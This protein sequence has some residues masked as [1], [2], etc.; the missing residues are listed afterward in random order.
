ML[1]RSVLLLI[2]S[3]FI[4]I[5]PCQAAD[6]VLRARFTIEAL[7]T[8]EFYKLLEQQQQVLDEH[9]LNL[10]I[11]PVHGSMHKSTTYLRVDMPYG[12]QHNST[13]IINYADGTISILD[14][15][16]KTTYRTDLSGYEE[17]FADGGL[18]LI[19]PER[20]LL[21]WRYML[22]QLEASP[23][24]QRAEVGSKVL[25]GQACQGRRF[26]ADITH[27]TS[28]DGL[29]LVPELPTLRNL[30]GQWVATVW[31]SDAHGL[32][33]KMVMEFCGIVLSLQLTHFENTS[34]AAV[35]FSSPPGY[36]IE[37]VDTIPGA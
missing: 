17:Q 30:K 20:L 14:H 8:P 5:Q 33:V 25:Y 23:H 11:Q 7:L 24:I 15:A 22:A 21:H 36:R 37:V 6:D 10:F 29:Q 27:M 3:L 1:L 2:A 28:A 35:L 16:S 34:G 19:S 13:S 31:I 18:P 4:L 9:Q 26:T 32:P 12:P